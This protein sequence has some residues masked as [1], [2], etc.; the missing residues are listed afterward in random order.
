MSAADLF[1]ALGGTP[2]LPGALCKGQAPVWDEALPPQRDPDPDDTAQRL[3]FAMAACRRCP[4]LT[5]CRAWLASLP[6][7][8][9]PTGV[10]AGQLHP[11]NGKAP[12]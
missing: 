7:R 10:V 12:Q 1:A 8:K 5:P 11:T 6:P 2:T 9:R 3:S 4:A